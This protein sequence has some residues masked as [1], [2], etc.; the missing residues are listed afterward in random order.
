MGKPVTTESYAPKKSWRPD[1]ISFIF[2]GE[3]ILGDSIRDLL[4][5]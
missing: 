4:I 2:A 3:H 1:E 5:S